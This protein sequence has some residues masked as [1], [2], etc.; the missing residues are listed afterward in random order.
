MNS[1]YS[2]ENNWGWGFPS[3]SVAINLTKPIEP[4]ELKQMLPD[5]EAIHIEFN[6]TE[7]RPLKV[8]HEEYLKKILNTFNLKEIRIGSGN[9]LEN[10]PDEIW[11]PS[12]EN[13]SI[14]HSTVN[15]KLKIKPKINL[16]GLSVDMDYVEVDEDFFV[17]PYLRELSLSNV[18]FSLGN[19]NPNIESITIH[20]SEVPLAFDLEKMKN[21]TQISL[22]EVQM[23]H[24]N[25]SFESH[26]SLQYIQLGH[27]NCNPKHWNNCINLKSIQIYSV[28]PLEIFFH[29][30]PSLEQIY[31]EIE[32]V[33]GTEFLGKMPTVNHF[34][35]N[36]NNSKNIRLQPELFTSEKLNSVHINNCLL[37]QSPLKHNINFQSLSLN[38]IIFDGNEEFLNHF[39]QI[40]VGKVSFDN[41]DWSKLSQ[42]TSFTSYDDQGGK[43]P[44]FNENNSCLSS[45]RIERSLCNDFPISWTK[46]P[47]LEYLALGTNELTLFPKWEEWKSIKK[48]GVTNVQLPNEIMLWK[49]LSVVNGY[50][51]GASIKLTTDFKSDIVKIT[52]DDNLEREVKLFIGSLLFD[53]IDTIL[54]TPN[55]KHNLLKIFNCKS[56][57]LKQLALQYLHILNEGKPIPTLEELST[58]SVGFLGKTKNSKSL[59]KEKLTALGSTYKTKVD[60]KTEVV[61]VGED[62]ELPNNF[63]DTEHFFMTEV[64]LDTL[65][66]DFQPGYIQTLET[67]ELH[68]LREL[69]W[70]DEVENEKIV[71]EML[72]GGGISDALLP[73]LIIVAKTSKDDSVKNALKRMLK[74]KLDAGGQ[75]ILSDKVNLRKPG[76]RNPF[77]EYQRYGSKI[78]VSQM[79]VTWAKR[80]KEGFS[81]FFKIPSSKQNPYRK[82]IFESVYHHYLARPHY[83]DL[84]EEFTSEEFNFILSQPA[85]QGNLKRLIL[86]SVNF[87]KVISGLLL[88]KDTLEDLSFTT[89]EKEL[90]EGLY[91]FKKLKKIVI[92]AINT[93]SLPLSWRSLSKLKHCRI[94]SNSLIKI[95]KD[96][97]PLTKIKEFY[98]NSFEIEK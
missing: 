3:G 31:I 94:Y 81:C 57:K 61:I 82:E 86:P 27:V 95:P 50:R 98:L 87:D 14:G 22:R 4:N 89:N 80:C 53:N 59:Y 62:F 2:Y 65:I 44:N 70:S 72:K 46:C 78:D 10:L 30:L 25:P 85:L 52:S 1:K 97:E 32:S 69:L 33:I 58:K 75:K 88:H 92:G 23:I 12:L 42:L 68:N 66:K 43:A 41:I 21:L 36:L 63:L 96:L 18:K 13:L 49:K 20:K 93:T 19:L 24:E 34:N 55:F 71:V 6:R 28:P 17:S 39:Q 76:W 40:N 84:R 37:P 7:F 56:Y 8:S 77:D 51:E 45:I 83:V 67:N 90:P 73:D 38:N 5:L 26:K 54:N 16:Q 79:A 9:R 91:E 60:N 29:Q 64:E 48:I 47:N 11:H 35:V 74:A 15:S